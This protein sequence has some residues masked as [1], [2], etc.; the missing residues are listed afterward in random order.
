MRK[1]EKLRERFET[2]K[3]V[4]LK[5]VKELNQEKLERYI[6][7][8]AIELE[9]RDFTHWSMYSIDEIYN[10]LIENYTLAE[11]IESRNNANKKSFAEIAMSFLVDRCKD[12]NSTVKTITEALDIIERIKNDY[13][14]SVSFFQSPYLEEYYKDI[15]EM[16]KKY[17]ER[18]EEKRK[19]RQTDVY[20][21][22]FKNPIKN[23]LSVEEIQKK[24]WDLMRKL[25][26]FDKTHL[27]FIMVIQDQ[28][29]NNIHKNICYD[30]KDQKYTGSKIN[31][32]EDMLINYPN[33]KDKME[34]IYYE[35]EWR[36][37]EDYIRY[38]L[39]TTE[40]NDEDFNYAFR[41]W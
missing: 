8:F 9:M 29:K 2:L 18:K 21:K 1:I 11:I 30:F 10:H 39:F 17:E 4:K 14:N 25:R 5:A 6:R 15:E 23:T 12:Y 24:Q 37:M 28:E 27:I 32:I 16:F 36:I 22:Y 19:F 26:T 20:K 35:L 3:A 31:L 40:K 41:G 34:P 13:N 33:L 7:N 38:G